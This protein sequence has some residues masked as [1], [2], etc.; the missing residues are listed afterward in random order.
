M[1]LSVGLLLALEAA[2]Y[3]CAFER[4]I[5]DLEYACKAELGKAEGGPLLVENPPEAGTVPEHESPTG[6]GA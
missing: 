5:V 1:A 6:D 3:L 4:E 2:G